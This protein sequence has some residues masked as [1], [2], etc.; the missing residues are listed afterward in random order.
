MQLGIVC[1]CMYVLHQCISS[2]HKSTDMV[3]C[4]LLV[5]DHIPSLTNVVSCVFS[6]DNWFSFVLYEL[7]VTVVNLF[8]LY[9]VRNPV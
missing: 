1:V 3:D 7:Y 8:L 5:L 9:A 4:L 6:L 2:M